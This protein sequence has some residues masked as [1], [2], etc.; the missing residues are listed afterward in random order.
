MN[1]I[2][3]KS[4]KMLQNGNE[5]R[6]N[7]GMRELASIKKRKVKKAIARRS[8]IIEGAEKERVKKAWRNIFLQA[9]ILK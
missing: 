2:G 1:V 3:I 9:G 7:G 4:V 8:K 6:L 5:R